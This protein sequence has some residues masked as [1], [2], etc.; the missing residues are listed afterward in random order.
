MNKATSYLTPTLAN[1]PTNFASFFALLRTMQGII[2][3]SPFTVKHV[4][5]A[6][7]ALGLNI[8]LD[9]NYPIV[10]VGAILKRSIPYTVN[11]TGTLNALR[12]VLT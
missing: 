1:Q 4:I 11:T 9:D 6:K 5:T 10:P 8:V 2:A 3:T 12:S 7:S